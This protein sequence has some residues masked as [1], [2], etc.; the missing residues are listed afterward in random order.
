MPIPQ[1]TLL[2]GKDEYI[3]RCMSVLSTEYDNK[4]AA[5]ICY[6]QWSNS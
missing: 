3:S 6:A 4:Q 5:A 2:E 1:P